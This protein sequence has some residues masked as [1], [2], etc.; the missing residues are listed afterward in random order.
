M[1]M[2]C[3]L[4]NK[5]PIGLCNLK[6]DNL[7]TDNSKIDDSTLIDNQLIIDNLNPQSK[8]KN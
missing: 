4:Q 7:K 1:H 6:I 3:K 5:L 2:G 8:I